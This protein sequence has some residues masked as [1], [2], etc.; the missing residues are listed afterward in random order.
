MYPAGDP[1]IN[2]RYI[3]LP[4]GVKVRVLES[5]PEQREAVL[6]VHGWGGS[7]YSF[8]ETIP[9]IAAAGY[10]AIAIDLPGHGLSD[11]PTDSSHYTTNALA[12]AVMSVAD[13][14]GVRRFTYVG[15]SLGSMLGLELALQGERRIERLVLISPP[16]LGRIPL[17][18]LLK[19]FSPSALNSLL[20]R[21]MSRGVL[22]LVLRQAFGTRTRPTELDI[23]EYWA[24]TQFDEFA[25]ACRECLHSV[26]WERLSPAHL[27]GLRLPVLVIVGERDRIVRG[28]AAR[29]KLIP[30]AQLVQLPEGG[31]LVMQECSTKANAKL[32]LFLPGG[33]GRK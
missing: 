27:R 14:L 12:K 17:L 3:A 16:A 33:R 8:S 31:H 4:D 18:P 10:R 6:L 32:L 7:V 28:A 30:T 9:A 15:H 23:E 2:V 25:V 26:A 13:A 24:P 20:P 1:R 11:K 21:L 19:L 29:A 5:I 22:E